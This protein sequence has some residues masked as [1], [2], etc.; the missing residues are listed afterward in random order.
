MKNR[1]PNRPYFPWGVMFVLWSGD[2]TELL[3]WVWHSTALCSDQLPKYL[4]EIP[5]MTN[6]HK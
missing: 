4:Y 3:T 5:N 6:Y 2:R 1:A